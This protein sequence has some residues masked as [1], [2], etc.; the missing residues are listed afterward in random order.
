MGEFT[1]LVPNKLKNNSKCRASTRKGFFYMNRAATEALLEKLGR[2]CE[3][4]NVYYDFTDG[5]VA[6][7]RGEG[8]IKLV[9][10]SSGRSYFST[11]G[12]LE[13]HHH[14]RKYEM[15]SPCVFEECG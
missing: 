10:Y 5:R 1:M 14:D 8:S 15:T 7:E 4:L 13:L 6:L 9:R 12:L 2:D 3:Y 11:C